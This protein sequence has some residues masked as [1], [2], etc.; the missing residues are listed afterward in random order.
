MKL[1]RTAATDGTGIRRHGAE[2]QAHAG[3]DTGVSL[4]HHAVGL[5]QAVETAVERVSIFHQELARAHHAETRAYLVAELGLYLVEIQRQLAV[6]VHFAARDVGDDF[7]MRGS[8][9]ELVVVAVFDLQHLRAEHFPAPGLLPQFG[10]LHGGHQQFDGAALVH[11]FAHYSLHFA[12]HA[13]P[14]RHPG[15]EPAGK[16]ADIAR[17]Q[18]Q[19]VTGQLGLGGGL[20]DGGDEKL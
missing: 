11:F 7:L 18:H 1:M 2:L 14:Q 9:A 5:F 20:L 16:F 6:A 3:E 8:E 19:T 12:Q 17:A 4:V 13:Q 10:G 15:I